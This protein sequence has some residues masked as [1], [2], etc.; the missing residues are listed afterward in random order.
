MALAKLENLNDTNL[1]VFVTLEPCSF[2]G[3]T[4]SCAKAII[5]KGIRNVV[6]GM[7]DPHP[8]N[9]GNGIQMLKDANVNVKVG[10]LQEQINYELGDYLI[11][12]E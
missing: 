10:V 6:V 12:E 2:H 1:T 9:Q 11:R 5:E 3:K 8:K 7:L 4:P